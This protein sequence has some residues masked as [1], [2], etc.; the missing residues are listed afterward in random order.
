MTPK[1][2][3]VDDI[4]V[5]RFAEQ[6]FLLC[7]NASNAAKDYRWIA[8]HVEGA[9]VT[10]R[11][12]EFA[13]LAVQGPAAASIVQKVVDRD[14]SGV[15]YYW[16]VE[17]RAAGIPAIVARTGY[18]GED[19]FELYIPWAEGPRLW[20]A[21]L[22]AGRPA[23][24]VPAG[25][26]ARDTLRLEAKMALYGND[27]DDTTTVL[28]ADLLFILKLDKGDFFGREA[29]V[30][31]KAAGLKR[32]LVGFELRGAGIARHGYEI[33]VDGRPAGTVTSGT[34]TPYLKK[35]IGLAYLPLGH[36]QPGSRFEIV[37]RDRA[38]AAEVVPTPF[39]KRKP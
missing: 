15:R 25:L 30:A 33:R 28:E 32:R 36:D 22:E 12:P 5:H 37:I 23:G 38:V 17:A 20:D 6:R 14:L 3:F 11:S 24:L 4:L 2:T 7:V 9:R 16:F 26:G 34:Q 18:T 8:E 1:G 29:L 39:Y 13:Q 19:G 27:I 31:Q 10:D 21:L 35:S